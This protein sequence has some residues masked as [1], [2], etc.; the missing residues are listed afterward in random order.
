VSK[1][2][3]LFRNKS[4]KRNYYYLFMP[5]FLKQN[6]AQGNKQGH[7]ANFSFSLTQALDDS[8]SGRLLLFTSLL[9]VAVFLPAIIHQQAV[10]GPII[11]AVLLISLLYLNLDSALLIGLIP[12]V[13]ALSRGLLPLPL[14]PMVPFIMLGNALYIIIFAQILKISSIGKTASKTGTG[15]AVI[16]DMQL[17]FALAVVLAA[18]SKF[19]FLHTM[20]QLVLPQLLPGKLLTKASL[21]LSW[22]Q[23]ITALAG[24]FIAWVVTQSLSKKFE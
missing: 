6:Q 1:D 24:G 17:G 20:S 22:P 5:D 23:L 21:M 9:A 12:S 11:N 2:A 4:N 8:V 18:G 3:Q 19:L 7:K 10:T 13:V 15:R 16:T 14:A